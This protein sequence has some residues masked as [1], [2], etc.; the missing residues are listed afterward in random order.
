MPGSYFTM[1]SFDLAGK[2]VL[3]RVDI[4]SP[5]DPIEGRILGDN[6]IRQHASTIQRLS[7]SKVI[8]LAHQSRPGKADFTELDVHARRLSRIMRKPVSFVDDLFGSK[9]RAA[10]GE[11]KPGDILML[12]NVRFYSEEVAFKDDNMDK[13]KNS[14]IVSNQNGVLY[15]PRGFSGESGQNDN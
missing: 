7:G 4:N 3:V 13:K 12:Q 8:I 2:T 15:N 10:I 1:D 6:R 11:M 9:A 5:I 14:H